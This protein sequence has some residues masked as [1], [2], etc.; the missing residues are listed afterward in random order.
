MLRAIIIPVMLGSFGLSAQC[1]DGKYDPSYN[2]VKDC[3]PNVNDGWFNTSKATQITSGEVKLAVGSVTRTLSWRLHYFKATLPGA[4]VKD[5]IPMILGLHPWSD[6]ATMEQLLTTQAAPMQYEGAWESVIILS[7]ALETGNNLN[8]WWDGSMVDGVPT[9]WAMD[10]IV[11]L[12]KDQIQNACSRLATA[13]AADLA[14]KHIDTN[15]VYVNGLSMGGSGTYHIGIRHP[16]LF[17]AIHAISGFADYEGGPCGNENFCTS[18]TN[19]FIGTAE[20]NL[21]MKG[22]DGKNYPARKYS[23]MSWFVGEHDGASWTGSLGKGRKYE[24]PYVV[25]THG[26]GDVTVHISSA[27]RLAAALKAKKFGYTYQRHTGGHSNEN[28]I[29]LDWLLS[30]RKNQSYLAFTNNSTDVTT[31]SAKYN[32]LNQIG[33]IPGTIKDQAEHYEV[34]MYGKGTTD[35]TLRRLQAFKVDP[36]GKYHWWLNNMVGEGTAVEADSAGVLTL[37]GVVVNNNTVLYVRPASVPGTS[38]KKKTGSLLKR[39]EK[40]C[41]VQTRAATKVFGRNEFPLQVVDGSGR[42]IPW[43][44]P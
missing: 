5:S 4:P 13:G 2:W 37:S 34:T 40:V 31:G 20:Q 21:M 19:T 41:L 9:T 43:F 28:F 38:V 8:T 24:P 25:L 14:N 1:I 18:F 26:T 33:W 3:T 32:Y 30:F 22:L 42:L 10:G 36:K 6:G 29:H 44:R 15:R 35:V 7:V 12:V 39:N 17:A 16:E 11:A 27:D 23:N